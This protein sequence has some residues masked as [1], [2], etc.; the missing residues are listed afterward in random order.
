MNRKGKLPSGVKTDKDGWFFALPSGK[1]HFTRISSDE[2]SSIVIDNVKP[3]PV[4]KYSVKYR[5]K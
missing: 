5:Y 4:A 1:S 2:D 3:G